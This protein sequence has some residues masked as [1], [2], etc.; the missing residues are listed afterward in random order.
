MVSVGHTVANDVVSCSRSLLCVPSTALR[1]RGRSSSDGG[2][3]SQIWA[4][5]GAYD[6]LVSYCRVRDQKIGTGSTSRVTLSN[7]KAAGSMMACKCKTRLRV[8]RH[9]PSFPLPSRCDL[10]QFTPLPGYNL[11]ESHNQSF[12][13]GNFD[14]RSSVARD[15]YLGCCLFGGFT[16]LNL[17]PVL[18]PVAQLKLRTSSDHHG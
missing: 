15:H 16:C 18:L 3:F 2:I 7:L 6:I 10:V 12:S 14:W 17:L 4:L 13:S 5:P 1:Y 11:S 8:F 9:A